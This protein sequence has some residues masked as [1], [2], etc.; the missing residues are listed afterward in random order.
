MS[1]P[2]PA[3]ISCPHCGK[4]YRYTASLAGRKV[5]CQCGTVMLMPQAPPTAP[6][7]ATLLSPPPPPPPE[8]PPP[9]EVGPEVNPRANHSTAP[10]PQQQTT[11]SLSD[12]YELNDEPATSAPLSTPAAR[13]ASQPAAAAPAVCPNCGQK[14]KPG[15]VLCIHCGTDLR[16][17]QRLDTQ[18]TDDMVEDDDAP[19]PA[20]GIAPAPGSNPASG[21]SPAHQAPASPRLG[22]MLA[23]ASQRKGLDTNALALDI[24]E[25]HRW[26]DFYNPLIILSIGLVLMLANILVIAPMTVAAIAQAW[27]APPGS[28]NSGQVMLFTLVFAGIRFVIQLPLI[29]AAILFI[30]R[31]F[32]TSYGTLGVALLKLVAIVIFAAADDDTIRLGLDALLSGLGSTGKLRWSLSFGVFI[33]LAIWLLDVEY[34]EAGVL[35][36]LMIFFP[37]VVLLALDETIKANFNLP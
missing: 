16:S 36:L 9:P 8:A 12:G 31:L 25:Q 20:P 34:L 15:A 1:E 4:R 11:E 10:T 7:V 17:G 19:A 35:Y 13:P 37:F 30:A 23:A 26:Q 2:Q 22:G 6:L 27:G 14:L 33:G 29:F 24:Q 21:S 3:P 28:V 32:G 18:V 5:K